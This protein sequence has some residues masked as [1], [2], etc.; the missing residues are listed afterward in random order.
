[1][2]HG[3]KRGDGPSQQ[4][5][6][7]CELLQQAF[8]AHRADDG[9]E[10]GGLHLLVYEI[11][12][13]LAHVG[14]VF[15][16]DRQVVYDEGKDAADLPL[17][18]APRRDLLGGPGR[19]IRSPALSVGIDELEEAYRL[20]LAFFEELEI[21]FREP[22]DHPPVLIR[23]DDIELHKVRADAYRLFRV[24]SLRLIIMWLYLRSHRASRE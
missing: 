19:R 1:M 23:Y 18:Q 5:L 8:A 11:Y 7:G 2:A 6:V 24:E 13:Q 15:E 12:K 14:Q 3:Q 17:G 4:V 9:D 20:L 22:F 21:I 10:V 16:A